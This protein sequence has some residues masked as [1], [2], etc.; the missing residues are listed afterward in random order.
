MFYFIKYYVFD[1]ITLFGLN[2]TYGVSNYDVFKNASTW[3]LLKIRI[4]I[5][6]QLSHTFI[7]KTHILDS[8]IQTL[9]NRLI[10]K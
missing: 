5:T 4:F 10:D 7:I 2:L 9:Q 1:A 6:T 8:F 3:N